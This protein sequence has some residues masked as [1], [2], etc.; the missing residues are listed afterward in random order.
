MNLIHFVSLGPGKPD[1][2]TLRVLHLLQEADFILCPATKMG[3]KTGSRAKTVISDLGIEEEKI[4]TFVLPMSPDRSYAKEAYTNAAETIIAE[5]R[6][7]KKI[8]VAAE[9]D[10]SIYASIHYMMNYIQKKGITIQQEC[11]IPSFIAATET[12]NFPLILLEERLA[13]VPGNVST[14][15]LEQYMQTHHTVVIMKLSRC[16]EAV[17]EFIRT[18]PHQYVYRYSENVSVEEKFYFTTSPE[19][20]LEKDFPYFSIL[21]IAPKRTLLLEED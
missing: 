10:I 21:T 1:L 18:Y 5:Y 16:K 15:E 13:V 9:G 11:G 6:T 7:G 12:E 17:K 3:S 19:D 4:H 2:V 8:V 20:I 14:E